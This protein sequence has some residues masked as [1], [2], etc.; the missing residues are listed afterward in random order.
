MVLFF[1]LFYV[2]VIV[3]FT[4]VSQI[5]Q[6]RA[7]WMLVDIK[8]GDMPWLS[9]NVTGSTKWRPS[10]LLLSSSLS[11]SLSP[12]HF[13]SAPCPLPT[14][15]CERLAFCPPIESDSEGGIKV[16]GKLFWIQ[17]SSLTHSALLRCSFPFLW[18]ETI[19][20]LITGSPVTPCI[21]RIIQA[22]LNLRHPSYLSH[23]TCFT[24]WFW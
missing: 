17:F 14:H 18:E 12:F 9:Y 22:K 7:S 23:H 13:S 6:S 20:L 2:V 3:V 5:F 15:C 1:V 8:E 11:V 16:Q 19:S 10:S 21:I 24:L 4:K